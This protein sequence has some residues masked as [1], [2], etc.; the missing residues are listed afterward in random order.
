MNL[1]AVVVVGTLAGSAVQVGPLT[2]SRD[3]AG[4]EA[5]LARVDAAQAELHQGRPAAFKALWSQADDVT[6]AGGFGGAIEKG[7]A[8]VSG[9]L[10]WAGAQ[11]SKGVSTRERV[12]S[13]TSGDIGY[14]VQVERLR[15]TVPGTTKEEARE[16]RVT[17]IFRRESSEWRMIHRQADGNVTRRPVK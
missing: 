1:A 17:M 4:F 8:A 5:M 12:A 6:L 16:L 7:W 15:F 11:F 2:V 14:V 9:R 3:A 10:D 13:G